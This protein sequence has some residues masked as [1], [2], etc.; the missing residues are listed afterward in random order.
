MSTSWW[1]LFNTS[2]AVYVVMA[3]GGGIRRVGWLT[4]EA[5]ESLMRLVIRVLYPC[6]I[7][8][9]VSRN[10][11]LQK[12][13]NLLLPPLLGFGSMALGFAAAM[14][15]ARLR[16]GI[17]GLQDGRERRT[18]AACVGIYNYGFIPIPLVQKLFDNST[19]G[20]LFVHN[21]GAE[22]AVWTLGVM[23]LSGRLGRRWWSGMINAP[24]IA[25]VLALAV[26][27][28]GAAHYLP[29]CVATALK[30]LGDSSVPM[31]MVLIGAVIADQFR[32]SERQPGTADRAKVVGWALLLRLG[33]LP[34]GFLLL[35]MALPC[36]VELKRV[37]AIQAAMPAA[38]FPIVLARHYGG[39]A[40]VGT[41][42]VLSTSLV[43]LI[44]IP[45]WIPAGL[46]LLR[47][48]VG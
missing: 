34:L 14:A 2:V 4:E 32:P 36:S 29:E 12:T 15:V 30:W 28:L 43:S 11:A 33:L 46:H 38:T 39:D 40:G 42:V 3:I 35:A 21:V 16:T 17:N 1:V 31:S 37:V 20:V 18:F 22:L 10:E 6:L 23:L 24:T 5:D 19:L 8:S 47:V 26:N 48:A 27:F 13:D 45:L 41:W 9:V 7:F 25:I 44:T